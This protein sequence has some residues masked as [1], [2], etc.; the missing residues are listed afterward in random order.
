MLLQERGD[1][2]WLAPFVTRNWLKHGMTVRC[3]NMPTNFGRTGYEVHSSADS[4]VIEAVVDPPTTRPPSRI[5]LRLRHP[6]EKPIKFITLNGRNHEDFDAGAE[7]IR[8][9]PT[10]KQMTI[11][12]EYGS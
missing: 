12:I 2:L 9:K 7:T 6:H 3:R 11:R 1:E 8:F 5:V 10:G 4:G